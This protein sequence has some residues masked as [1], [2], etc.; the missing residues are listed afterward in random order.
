MEGKGWWRRDE[1][2]GRCQSCQR[3]AALAPSQRSHVQPQKLLSTDCEG[4]DIAARHPAEL[5]SRTM[6][7]CV[8]EFEGGRQPNRDSGSKS[9]LKIILKKTLTWRFCQLI[10]LLVFESFLMPITSSLT[11]AA[12][13]WSK[14]I[15]YVAWIPISSAPVHSW[16]CCFAEHRCIHVISPPSVET[17]R[18]EEKKKNILHTVCLP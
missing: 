6:C 18:G 3:R 14:A 4:A 12:V 7:V 13:S 8:R 1:E 5:C 17:P 10:A 11:T 2:W 16:Y 9:L 15:Y